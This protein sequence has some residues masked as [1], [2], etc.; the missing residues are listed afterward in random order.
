MA[1]ALDGDVLKHLD[2]LI[3]QRTGRSNNDR[4]TGM[5]AEGVEVLH[6]CNGEA[7]VVSVADGFEFNLLPALQRLLDKNLRSKGEGTLGQFLESFLV[8]ADT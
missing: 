6:R 2:L 8:R 4:L 7:M 1:D 5:N 3:F